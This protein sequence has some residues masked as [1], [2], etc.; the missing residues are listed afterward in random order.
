MAEFAKDKMDIAVIGMACK[1]AD[2][3]NYNELYLNL[4]NKVDSV[5][6]LSEERIKATSVDATAELRQIGYLDD[7]DIFDYKFFKFSLAEAQM[8][9]PYQRKMVEI[10]YQTFEDAGY[11]PEKMDGTNTAVFVADYNPEYY[12]LCETFQETMVAGNSPAFLATRVARTFNLVGNCQV[13]DTACSSSL[14]ALYSACN[15]LILEEA[16]QALVCAANINLFPYRHKSQEFAIW[17]SDDKSRAFSQEADGMSCG[18][19]ISAI[20]IKSLD[21]AIEDNDTI[22]A[23]I[24]GIAI[25]NNANRSAS[26][27]APDSISQAIVIKHAWEKA[28]INPEKLE[29]IEAHGSGTQLGDCLEVEGLTKAFN[30]YTNKR[31]FCAISTIKSNIGH[32][33]SAAGIISV[34]KAILSL[35][36]KALLPTIHFEY[37]NEMID[38][39]NTAIY[40]NDT[41]KEWKCN[42]KRLA[43]VTSLGASGTNVHLVLEEV[44]DNRKTETAQESPVLVLVSGFSKEAFN[45]NIIELKR[46]L[47]EN[48]EIS[49]ND[50]AYTL[51]LGRNHFPYRKAFVVRTREELIEQLNEVHDYEVCKMHKLILIA[52]NNL[53]ADRCYEKLLSNNKSFAD[54]CKEKKI[55][56]EFF[57]SGGYDF[58]IKAWLYE[59]LKQRNLASNNI[60]AIENGKIFIEYVKEVISFQEALNKANEY[61][62]SEIERMDE[63]VYQMVQREVT[64]GG[65]IFLNLG[66]NCD[67]FKYINSYSQTLSNV[68]A[69]TFDINGD[70]STELVE[71]SKELYCHN[72]IHS[73]DETSKLF[74]GKR[75][76]LPTY[77]FDQYRCWIRET[78]YVGW[79]HGKADKKASSKIFETEL[80]YLEKVVAQAWDVVLEEIN[81][82]NDNF[83]DIGGDSLKATKVINQISEKLKVDLSFEDIFDFQTIEELAGYVKTLLS[84]IDIVRIIWSEVLKEDVNEDDD[85]FELGGHSLMGNQVLNRVIN[86]FG[87]ELNFDEMYAN[88]QLS[89]FSRLIEQK[90]KNSE[91]VDF[92]TAI[93]KQ[94]Y[95]PAADA[96][97]R[98]WFLSQFENASVS[99]NTPF[100]IELVGK[101]DIFALKKALEAIVKRHETLRTVFLTIDG[102]IVQKILEFKELSGWYE[103]VECNSSMTDTDIKKLI[104]KEMLKKFDLEN[105]P[106]FL[107][108]IYKLN[109]DRV[110]FFSN[111]H[112]I[113]NDGWSTQV[114]MKELVILYNLYAKGRHTVLPSLSIQYKDYVAWLTDKKNTDS[115]QE[116][117]NYWLREY[118]EEITICDF[119]TDYSRPSKPS[120]SGDIVYFTVEGSLKNKLNAICKAKAV[121]LY[122]VL[123]CAVDIVIYRYTHCS[124]VITGTTIAGRRKRELEEQ[125]GLYV[126]TLALRNKIDGEK[127]IE[128]VLQGVQRKIIEG[129][130][131]QQYPFDALVEDV[132]IRRDT[133]RNP[134]FDIM[135]EL[136]NTSFVSEGY[137]CFDGITMKNVIEEIYT[138]IFDMNIEFVENSTQIAG[139]I[140][141]N[142]DI[143]VRERIENFCKHIITVLKEV[144][145]DMNQKIDDIN[146]LTDDDLKF[147]MDYC[148]GEKIDIENSGN[149]I[150]IIESIS[151]TFGSK[152]AVREVAKEI[153][154]EQLMKKTDQV[155]SCLKEKSE[156]IHGDIIGVCLARNIDLIIVVLAIWK[157]G[158]VYLP[159]DK[160]LPNDRKEQILNDCNPKVVIV[161]AEWSEGWKTVN[162]LNLQDGNEIGTV[163]NEADFCDAAY[164]IY[165]SGSTGKPKGVIV[166]H[167]GLLNHLKA[168]IK[169]LYIDENDVVV[170]NASICFDISIWQLFAALLVGGT[171]D[172][173]DKSTILNTELFVNRLYKDGVTLCE[174][175]PSYFN[176]IMEQLSIQKVLFEKLR[177]MI[178]TGENLPAALVNKWFDLYNDIVLVNAYGPTEASDDILHAFIDRK[179]L[180]GKVPLGKPIQNMDVYVLDQN[181]NICPPGISGEIC[182]TGIGVGKGY[183]NL[184]EKTDAAFVENKKYSVQ[185]KVYKTGDIGFLN[186]DG[187][188]VFSGRCDSQVK[189]N[190]FRIELDE[191]YNIFVLVAGIDEAV[192]CVKEVN[193]K[194]SICAYYVAQ[195]K[196]EGSSIKEKLKKKLPQ[197]MVPS[198]FVKV[199]KI[200]VTHNGKVDYAQLP[201]PFVKTSASNEEGTNTQKMILNAW[202][203]VLKLDEI[204]LDDNFFDLGGDSIKALQV[205]IE[206]KDA[207]FSMDVQ[208]IFENQTVRELGDAMLLEDSQ[209]ELKLEIESKFVKLKETVS[210]RNPGVEDAYP[211]S[212]IEQ[213]LLFHSLVH[214]K[215]ITHHVQMIYQ[216]KYVD[217]NLKLFEATIKLMAEKHENLRSGFNLVD[218]EEPLKIVYRS[219]DVNI[220]YRDF[221]Q[222]SREEQEENVHA[223]LKEDCEKSFDFDKAPLWRLYVLNL[224][225]SN[226]LFLFIF[227]QAIM[228]GWSNGSLMNEINE[229]YNSLILN[230]KF[231]PAKLANSYKQ[232]VE[233]QIIIKQK[234]EIRNFWEKELQDYQ[235]LLLTQDINVLDKYKERDSFR[236][237]IDD[238]YQKACEIAEK[239]HITTKAI[240]FSIYLKLL[241]DIFEQSDITVGILAHNRP[242]CKEGDKI[243]GYFLNMV[244]FRFIFHHDSWKKLLIDVNEKLNEIKK[245]EKMPLSEIM[246]I[247][248]NEFKGTNPI[249]DT[250]FNYTDFFVA[251]NVENE[252]TRIEDDAKLRVDSIIETNTLFDINVDVSFKDVRL[253]IDTSVFDNKMTDQISDYYRKV[254]EE[255]YEQPD[256]IRILDLSFEGKKNTEQEYDISF[257]F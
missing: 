111:A 89:D 69:Y 255:L 100:A 4:K 34:I 113:I 198:H 52:G 127:T 169:D 253:K 53:N 241:S 153:S 194:N 217:F 204:G 249:T 24:K 171:V 220:D 28:G 59:E 64:N 228:D 117:K 143:F 252:A 137:S 209:N 213:G 165:T 93:E 232:F 149:V 208:D 191:I 163:N 48:Q 103:E 62:Y 182:V 197:Y 161:D 144:T 225:N 186:F 21:K 39:D 224:G 102:E 187:N 189:I 26:P 81:S 234:D 109:A 126:N 162:V 9:D 167:D 7:V 66:F 151:K 78:P 251:E 185:H 51:A 172:I 36:K 180:N 22:H 132:K 226:Y 106:L 231:I 177:F 47:M 73:F 152:I 245:Y 67:L 95:Y 90:A 57:K 42:H 173:C 91:N 41:F 250:M 107:V 155:A 37:P 212:D 158:A 199:D 183:Y 148:I 79:K 96:Q 246:K 203:K 87:V 247:T 181:M 105:G 76:H 110:I 190:G 1:V 94:E 122:A 27:S 133:S 54:Y 85:F 99:Y 88:S 175:V 139:S 129:Y 188:F 70:I 219:V 119:P 49:L 239:L 196:I 6:R 222:L 230:E 200:P 92:I 31:K 135:I 207:G 43:A 68:C 63:R 124:D 157:L 179:I 74:C 256:D 138:S 45:N 83:F 131:H 174:V 147:V 14:V 80:T 242:A 58:V 20:L 192:V 227:H 235:R 145:I 240:Y 101:V 254:I 116:D 238:I 193:G 18:E 221:E 118:E 229:T 136:H 25:N 72:Y 44:T 215:S 60:L 257:N 211:M 184:E 150:D 123:L 12:Q 15:E 61:Q 17:A 166:G 201:V 156:V 97:K 104:K 178:I 77:I 8:M 141:Y 202:K 130:D 154:Y 216:A 55:Y 71:I 10:V 35:E 29:F 223:L 195:Q 128:Q 112:H 75:L 40:V 13:I 3:N 65:A 115:Y 16:D 160:E 134:L 46:Y 205:A 86:E 159:L 98:L 214:K 108:K 170:Q 146:Y 237:Q 2:A 125:I 56:K 114:F 82:K 50:V 243:V 32:A 236:Y 233:E 244:P 176:I 120:Y 23:V 30:E 164:M 11:A 84:T 206:V 38:F 140:I 142:T 210:N 19:G 218:Y 121:S 168:K 5:K 248:D 33:Y